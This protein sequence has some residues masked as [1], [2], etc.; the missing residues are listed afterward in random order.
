MKKIFLL[1]IFILLFSNFVYGVPELPM[2]ISGD[3]YINE[4][5]A[6]IG[7]EVSAK[8]NDKEVVKIKTTESGKFTI[9]LQKLNEGDEVKLYVNG[10]YSEQS[11]SYKNGNFKQLILKVK[12]SYL[13]YY[14]LGGIAILAIIIIIWKLSKKKN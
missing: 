14:L 9:L 4:K 6:K 11:I 8:V 7:T 1:L 2:I 12:K 3:V 10:I 5:P 13:V